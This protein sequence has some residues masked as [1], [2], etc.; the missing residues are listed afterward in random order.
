MMDEVEVS[1]AERLHAVVHEGRGPY[2]LLVHGL[3]GSRSY[4]AANLAA[5]SGVCR[6]VVVE[7]WGHG[8][9][10][11]PA[12][13]SRYEP[14][15]YATEFERLRAELGAPRW[16][17]IGK[18]MG[19]RLTLDY[20]LRHPDRVLAQVVTNSLSAFA[21][22][23][24]WRQR[25][26][27]SAGPLVERLRREGVGFLR[28]AKI[29]PGR[30]RRVA[31]ATRR[32]M[33]AE[34]DEHDAVGIANSIEFTNRDLPLGERLRDVSAPT[35]LTVGVQEDGF[36][37]LVEQVR[38]IPGLEIVELPAGHAVNAHDAEGWNAA[39]VAFLSRHA[40]P[41]AGTSDEP[42]DRPGAG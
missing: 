4:W 16:M 35:L 15:T 23:E 41:E 14:A 27:R 10:P 25:H 2:A 13:P 3:F 5:L 38:L 39:V 6:P 21:P 33:A 32:L 11:S 28:H 20:G 12:D 40:R 19:A 37:P 34:F 31:E 42:P 30:S 1:G 29:N 8:R 7:L 17:T 26:A 36:L 9:S 22:V 24:G 18:S